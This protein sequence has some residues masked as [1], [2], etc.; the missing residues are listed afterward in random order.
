VNAGLRMAILEALVSQLIRAKRLVFSNPSLARALRAAERRNAFDDIDLHEEMLADAVRLSAYHAAIERYVT[1]Q[2]YVVDVG[3]GTGVLA[4][5]AAAKNPRK[6]C[7]LDHSKTL[8]EY[9]RAAAEANGI[10]NLTFV[11]ST[12][13]KFRPAEPIDVI[14]QEQMGS[15]LFDE[16]MVATILD[17]RDRCLKPGGRIL[18]AK[19]EFFLEPVQL[20][21]QERIPLI[22][23][24]R[25]HGLK[26]PPAL[27]APRAAYHFR[28]I[29]PGDVAFL[30]CDPEPVFAFDLATLTPDQMPKWFSVCKPIIRSGQVDGIGIYFKATFDDDISF[31]TGPEAAKTHWPMVLYRTHARVCGAGEIFEMEVEVPELSEHLSWSWRIDIHKSAGT[32]PSSMQLSLGE[33]QVEVTRRGPIRRSSRGASRLADP[34]PRR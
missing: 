14:V 4:F 11:A 10:A 15:V 13:R 23:E 8:L 2:D 19:F 17:L 30:L 12:S 24:Q 22:H 20:L 28:E 1:S 25:L 33:S 32:V 16:G 6:I 7:A 31:S 27:V 5:L 21:E 34:D 9:A 26:F 3:T 29:D 18:P